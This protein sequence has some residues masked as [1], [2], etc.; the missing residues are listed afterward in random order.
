MGSQVSFLVIDAHGGGVFG[1]E[2]FLNFLVLLLDGDEGGGGLGFPLDGDEG[3]DG[4]GFPLVLRL[5]LLVNLFLL[6]ILE[7]DSSDESSEKDDLFL[8]LSFPEGPGETYGTFSLE[9]CIGR[10]G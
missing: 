4:L 8:L 9:G 1:G 5:L 3:G 10:S 2:D 7:D 6:P